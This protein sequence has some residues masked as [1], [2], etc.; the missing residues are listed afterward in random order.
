MAPLAPEDVEGP[1]WKKTSLFF[2]ALTVTTWVFLSFY[3][4]TSFEPD[5]YA[6][7]LSIYVVDFDGGPVGS[8]LLNLTADYIRNNGAP[9]TGSQNIA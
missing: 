6:S 4:G 8:Y 5:R 9:S 7:E 3:L 2:A 1:V